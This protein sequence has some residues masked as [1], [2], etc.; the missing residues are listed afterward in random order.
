MYVYTAT[1]FEGKVKECSE[2]TLKWID[3]DKIYDLPIWE[4]DKLF[5]K[6]MQSNETFFTLKV[7]YKGDKLVKGE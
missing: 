1:K 2:G 7:E 3:K 4:G 5:L 6:R